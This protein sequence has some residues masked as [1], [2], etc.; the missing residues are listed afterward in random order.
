MRC[1]GAHKSV[2]LRLLR[3][4]GGTAGGR[5][6]GRLSDYLQ[7]SSITGTDFVPQGGAPQP[8]ALFLKAEPPNLQLI[9]CQHLLP[10]HPSPHRGHPQ[11][12]P[13]L[14]ADSGVLKLALQL[15]PYSPAKSRKSWIY[16]KA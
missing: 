3:E 16:G 15:K 4:V 11:E 9:I 14:P 12:L 6:A 5:L 13:P 1:R 10:N 8:P 2:L 7:F